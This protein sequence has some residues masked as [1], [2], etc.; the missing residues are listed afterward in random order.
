MDFRNHLSQILHF[1]NEE[2]KPSSWNGGRDFSEA[3][4][5]VSARSRPQA[6]IS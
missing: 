6:Q 3:T 4:Q 2:V 1:F 5:S